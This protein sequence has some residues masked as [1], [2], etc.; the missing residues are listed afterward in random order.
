MIETKTSWEDSGYDCDHCGG[1]IFK[2]TDY[3]TRRKPRICYQ[4]RAC[5]CQW[6]IN[7]STLRVGNFPECQSA[8]RQRERTQPPAPRVPNWVLGIG[9]FIFLLLV[10]R[11]GGLAALRLL[12]PLAL[13]V[14]ALTYAFRF[15]RERQWW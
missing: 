5:G 7:G 2:R 10:I 3:E 4:C 6:R 12:V 9:V 14:A 1:Q 13:A 8:Q 15:G 11:F